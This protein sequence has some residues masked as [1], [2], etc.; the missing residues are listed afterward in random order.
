MKTL[1]KSF[2]ENVIKIINNMIKPMF[3]NLE[4]L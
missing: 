1:R 2:N 3:I 4:T